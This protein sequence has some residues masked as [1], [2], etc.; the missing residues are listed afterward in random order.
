MGHRTYFR[1]YSEYIINQH[2]SSCQNY[3]INSLFQKTGNLEANKNPSLFV[4][5][6]EKNC[7][8]YR[9]FLEGLKKRNK[10][11]YI[12]NII[13]SYFKDRSFEPEKMRRICQGTTRFGVRPYFMKYT[14]WRSNSIVINKIV[15]DNCEFIFRVSESLRRIKMLMK[16][17]YLKLTSVKEVL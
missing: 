12:I 3:W 9:S 17:H 4:E 8:K 6:I 16:N 14:L 2:A 10:A 11:L 7:M 13:I 15:D 5:D 1:F